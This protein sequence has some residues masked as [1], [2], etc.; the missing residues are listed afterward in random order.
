MDFY[1]FWI[2]IG[3]MICDINKMDYGLLVIK[4]LS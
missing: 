3:D 4:I 1:K 2:D